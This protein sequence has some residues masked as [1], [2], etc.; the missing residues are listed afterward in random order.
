MIECLQARAHCS[1]QRHA[2]AEGGQEI[3][4]VLYILHSNPHST[5]TTLHHTPQLDSFTTATFWSRFWVRMLL[6]ALGLHFRVHWMNASQYALPRTLSKFLS[7][8]NEC[9]NKCLNKWLYEERMNNKW[10]EG[11]LFV[12]MSPHQ[13]DYRN[14]LSTPIMPKQHSKT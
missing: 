1:S 7:T 5:T 8:R 6:I 13:T 14:Y 10:V 3:V 12:L 11:R 9:L 2:C 4:F